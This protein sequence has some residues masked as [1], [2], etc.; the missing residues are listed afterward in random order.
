MYRRYL[1]ASR[2]IFM[3]GDCCLAIELIKKYKQE[4]QV[5]FEIN[6]F[7]FHQPPVQL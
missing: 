1:G 2:E 6:P 4:M 5:L 3:K 7:S